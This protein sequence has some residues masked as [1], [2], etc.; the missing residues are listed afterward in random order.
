MK[1]LLFIVV[2]LMAFVACDS[3]EPLSVY[4]LR[5]E[6]LTNPTAIDSANPHFSWKIAA[7]AKATAQTHYEI[8]VA[9]SPKALQRGEADGDGTICRRGI[10]VTRAG[11]LES[12][13][14]G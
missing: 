10:V 12:A 2:A 1:R 4:D 5:C 9:T 3:V 13:R 6:D 8:Q 14:V 11:I 7:E